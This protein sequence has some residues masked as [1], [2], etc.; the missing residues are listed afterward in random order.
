MIYPQK[1][2]TEALLTQY[3]EGAL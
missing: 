1:A 3:W 2:R